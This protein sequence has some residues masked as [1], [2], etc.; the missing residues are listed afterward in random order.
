MK[1]RTVLIS[2]VV[3]AALVGGAGY[4]A[5]YVTQN[6]KSPVDVVPVSNV[7]MGYYGMDQ[8]ETIY[9]SVTSQIAQ[10][11][12]LNDEYGLEKVYVN[13]G[14][15]VK[16]GTPLLSYDMTLQELELEMQ[17]LELQ[18]NQLTLTR[19]EKE[20]DKLKNTPAT[21][22]LERDWFTLTASAEESE[23]DA[24]ELVPDES[25]AGDGEEP[26]GAPEDSGTPPA[27]T[28]E[29]NGLS[30]DGVET[31]DGTQ[32]EG[33]E[34]PTIE[35][36]VLS[37]GR[38][39]LE[40]EATFLACGDELKADDVG[41]AIEQAVLYYRKNLADEQ[42][43]EEPQEDG[44]T[45]ELRAYALRESV[46]EAISEEELAS[47][48]ECCGT[49][50]EYQ[51]RYVEMLI[52]EA[53]SLEPDAL[54]EAVERIQAAYDLLA[55]AQQEEVENRE[56]MEQLAAQAEELRAQAGTD[57]EQQSDPAQSESDGTGGTD[58]AQS[59]SDGTGGIDPAQSESGETGETDSAQ[60]E[61]GGTE[62]SDP[63][64]G[65]IEVTQESD[66]SQS[67]AD[68]QQSDPAPEGGGETQGTDA[69]AAD[70]EEVRFN[71]VV[72]DVAEGASA[73]VRGEDVTN[74]VAMAENGT[75]VFSVGL[76]SGYAITNVLVDGTTPARKNEAS[77]DPND[78]VIEGIQTNDTI[79]TVGTQ[80]TQGTGTPE[81]SDAV[82]RADADTYLV[83]ISPWG[84]E[85]KPY[86][87]GDLVPLNADLSDVTLAFLGWSVAPASGQADQTVELVDENIDQGYAS[88]FMPA[89]DVVA[90]ARYQDAPDAIDSYTDTFL[91]NAE[92]LLAENAEQL[93]ADEGKD[94]VTE[95]EGAVVFYQQWLSHAEEE[96]QDELSDAGQEM[97]KYLLLENVANYLT[98][99]GKG[100]RVTQLTESYR[101][102]CLLYVK[103]M[104]RRLDP[105]MLDKD[106]LEKA[107]NAYR[108]LGVNWQSEL[109]LRWEDEQAALAE[110]AGMPWK[111]SKKGN[112]KKP[113][114]FLSIGDTLAA[115]TV[116][117]MFQEYLA[118]PL[119]TTTEQERYS[120]LMDIWTKYLELNDAQKTLTSSAP[121]FIDTFRQYG[122]WEDPE[123]EP[124]TDFPG[125]YDDFDY[126][127]EPM[128][129]ADELKEMI[130]DKEN[131][132]KSCEL[133]IKQSELDLKQKQ[134]I[135]DGKVVKSTMDGTVVS[136]GGADGES[137]EDYFLKISNE[138]GL[139]AKGTMSELSLEKIHVGDTISGM[140]QM[141]G[142]SFTAVIK[143]ISEYP[144]TSSDYY[145]YGQG[146]SN[147]S[148]YPF[149][150][151]IEDTEDIEEGDAEIYLT[152]QAPSM[153]GIY[154]ENYFV[155]S[156][157]DGR[158]YVYKKAEDG[159]LTKQYVT[160]GRN[161]YG[162]AMEIVDG[163]ELTDCIAFP[164]GK[165]VKEG[166]KTNEV[167]RLEM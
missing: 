12:R 103:T 20:L 4:G 66:P 144:E 33:D 138:T 104:F 146:N 1:L 76:E 2:V 122:L 17:Q 107:V 143:E 77:E 16:E 96:V 72:F 46:K 149:Y 75:I 62:E 125:G 85:P 53:A 6:Q 118:L 129:T 73:A 112:R 41:E 28:G 35:D 92:K 45:V 106:L 94:F 37:F 47:L 61:S 67:G 13:L 49:L 9:G 115:Y 91:A 124:E 128:Y 154:L 78:Y 153:D 3:T 36:S 79:V 99:Q 155:R 119:E 63:A 74:S 139:Y 32:P 22:S 26:V 132:I 89:F 98:N 90:T 27:D 165:D 43:A 105:A 42:I 30:V 108:L 39:V 60:S 152:G 97:E 81:K 147:A 80:L 82:S 134:R 114:D 24:E 58:P 159:T 84:G 21:A 113:K 126:P 14:D 64:L 137:D 56:Q 54:P 59:E 87:A 140:L 55:S 100:D 7:S 70:Q 156:E 148:Y 121:L 95:L 164:Y 18:T 52:D 167:D 117:Q 31:V 71:T 136:V 161:M 111:I 19:L 163:L 57:T 150:A 34:P 110:Q 83:T 23:T 133:D 50:D 11:V 93:C 10:T 145:G 51:L 48:T 86:K 38:L 130:Q 166:A 120:K 131:E 135:V 158:T 109:E 29:T 116:M 25:G 102:L 5:Y 101:E 141:T 68:A 127:D 88:F 160:T 15:E 142:V 8:Q 151:L 65:N 44:T 69:P 162:Y 40:I 123:M 157:T